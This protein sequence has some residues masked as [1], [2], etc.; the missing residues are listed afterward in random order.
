MNGIMY[1][2]D[3]YH[4]MGNLGREM[5]SSGI[6]WFSLGS[7]HGCPLAVNIND[8]D[9]IFIISAPSSHKQLNILESLY[10]YETKQFRNHYIMDRG[11][12]PYEC[13]ALLRSIVNIPE[14]VNTLVL[15]EGIDR[16]YHGLHSLSGINEM[17]ACISHLAHMS[18]I[19]SIITDDFHDAYS[20]I[21]F[22]AETSGL[23]MTIGAMTPLYSQLAF[24]YPLSNYNKDAWSAIAMTPEGMY[25]FRLKNHMVPLTKGLQWET[26]EEQ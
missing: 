24:G 3:T 8:I 20:R 11:M 19:K 14:S 9:S 6:F 5:L 1:S 18:N 15:L 7:C 12:T 16:V 26:Q 2:M 17:N 21:G 4:D 25:S 23:V 10:A 13:R 22:L